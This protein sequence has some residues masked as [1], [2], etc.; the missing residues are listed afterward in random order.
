MNPPPDFG[1]PALG[2]SPSGLSVKSAYELQPAL[3]RTA[4][5][6]FIARATSGSAVSTQSVVQSRGFGTSEFSFK[7][8]DEAVFK[9][10]FSVS[11]EPGSS[12][13]ASGPEP[14]GSTRIAP[15]GMESNVPGGAGFS[16]LSG[17]APSSL[18]FSFSRPAAAPSISFP[19]ASHPHKDPLPGPTS[20]T[21]STLEFTFSHPAVPSNSST[22]Q[23][24]GLSQT[25]TIPSSP[26]SFSFSAKVLQPTAGSSVSL[27]GGGGFGQASAFGELKAKPEAALEAA[28]DKGGDSESTGEVVFGGQGKGT[29][30]KEEPAAQDEAQ[31]KISKVDDPQA[32]GEA[33]RHPSKRPL[34]RSRFPGGGLFR[35]AMTSLM[36]SSVKKEAKEEEEAQPEWEEVTGT[37]EAPQSTHTLMT[38][39]RSQAP[40]REI[41]EKAEETETPARRSRRG[42]S[43]DSLGGMSPSDAT[44]IQCKNVPPNLNRKDIIEKH[45]SRFGKL[46]RVFCRPNKNLAI[47]HFHDH[48]S[49]A[50]AKKRGKSLHRHEILIFWQRKK[51]SPGEKGERYAEVEQL[52]EVAADTR[53]G[54]FQS[55]PLRKPLARSPAVGSAGSLTKGSPVKKSSIAKTLQFDLE[56]QLESGSDSPGTAAS[57]PSSLQ[58]L[59]GQVCETAEE[60]YRLL[61]QRDKILRQ[62]R[63][64]RTDLDMSKVFVGTCP[65]MC[66]EKERYMRETRNQLSSYEVVPNTEKVDHAAAIKEYSRS[67]ADQEEP[68]PHELRPLPVLSMTMDYLVTQVMDQGQEN[69]RDWYDFVWNR[70]RG[71]R[72]DITQQHLCDPLTVSLIEKCTRFHIHCAHHL[73]QEPMMS[74]D[75]KIN[76]E[77]MTK[78]LQ[79]LKEMYQDLATREV[80]CSREAEFRQ[81]NVLLKLNDGDI[82]REVQQFRSE[83]RNST[84]VNFAVQAFAALNNNNFVRFFKLV[85]AASYLAGCILHRYFNQ[86]RRE[87]LRALN[88]A[89]TVGAQRSTSFPVDDLVRMLMFRNSA[90]AIDFVQ[91]YGLSVCEGMVELNRTAFQDPELPVPLKKS[92]DIMGKMT[93]LIG[94]VVNGGPLPSPPQHTPVYSFDSHNKYRGE[95][96]YVDPAFVHKGAPLGAAPHKQVLLPQV[97]GEQEPGE[98]PEPASASV[99]TQQLFPPMGLP[100]PAKPPSSPPKPEPVYSDQD[101]TAEIESV[102]DEVLETECSELA[103]AVNEYVSTA[104]GVCDSQVE[105]VMS[106]VLEQMLRDLSAAEIHMEKERIAEEKRKMEEARRKEEHELFLDQFGE[107]LCSEISQEVLTE[108]IKDTAELEIKQA[109]EEKAACLARSSEEV[110]HSLIEETLQDEISQLAQGV[111]EVELRRIYK[112]LKRWHDVVA[113]RRQLK[114][115]MRGFPAAPCF[116]DPRFKLKALV[117]SV[118]PSLCMER[119]AQGVV[120]LGN[121]GHMAVSCTRLLK[122][123]QEAI[124]QM[125][126]QHYYQRLLSESVW[127]PLDLP[128][129]VAESI[130]DHTNRIFWKS[131]LLLPSNQESD[132]SIANR[133][134]TDWLEAKFCGDKKSC[135]QSAA[136]EGKME[137]LSISNDLLSLA[138]GSQEVHTCVKVT[139]GPLSEEGQ[140]VMEKQKELLGTSA[141][142]L[143]LPSL[144]G[145]REEGGEDE[146]EVFLLSALLQLRQL[147]QASAGMPPLP[148]VVVVPE[149]GGPT[150][151]DQ[152]LEGG[153]MLPALVEDGLISEYVFIHIPETINDLQ[154]S[155][156]VSQAVKWLAARSPPPVS[157]ASQTLVEFV[158][159]GLCREFSARLYQDKQDREGAG[160]PCQEPAPIIR[161]YNSVLDFLSGLVSADSLSS[162]SWPVTEFCT[163]ATRNLLPHLDWNCPDHL[164]WIRRAVL[165]LQIPEWDLP[166]S[167]A[168]WPQLCAS[169]FQYTSQIPSSPHSQ[170]LLMSRLENLLGRVLSRCSPGAILGPGCNEDEECD[171][172]G[173]SFHQVPW[174]EILAICIDHRLKDW[175]PPESPV[176]EDAITED[177][178]ILVYFQREKLKDFEPPSCW[179]EAVNQTHR[180]KQQ[181]ADQCTPVPGQGL[182]PT[183]AV[184]RLRQNLFPS[185]VETQPGRAELDITYTPSPRELLP[186]CILASLQDEKTKNQKFEEQLQ[187]WLEK[188]PLDSFSMP[189][190]MPSS[191]ISVPEIMAPASK[192]TVS[193]ALTQEM[194]T[195][196]QGE[197]LESNWLRRSLSLDQRLK[198][199]K[200]L[201]AASQKEERACGL[202]LNSLLEIVE[203]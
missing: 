34:M 36:K 123:R 61:E 181:Q 182:T 169:I 164:A 170:P 160:L 116:V 21:N 172:G 79:S 98:L 108:C 26:S 95:G 149:P 143:L 35:S 74:F 105:A 72:K 197:T 5:C 188:D 43:T 175:R 71:I 111:L 144:P 1:Q 55:S 15:T 110:S 174:D 137:T 89:Y 133:I 57:L 65:D 189:A 40:T 166:P 80:Y 154:G 59:V 163:P 147:Q 112:F 4:I 93:V 184:T 103:R 3:F 127:T 167:S 132:A 201:M 83:V 171:K 141:L 49:A 28:A 134:L 119:L 60:K 76:N 69:Y 158:E 64:K 31:G 58:H 125:R 38:P 9:P 42:E 104:L 129:L 200:R 39:P 20:N 117:P 73:C 37:E 23:G 183:P 106:E 126:V 50:R 187:R 2:Q 56:P 99:T 146:E 25:A 48:A 150:V 18:G 77:N 54:G 156:Q 195:D 180:D 75:A 47:V 151:S 87:A 113:V 173:L 118:S 91:Q 176:S 162:L 122:M 13:P 142:L 155:E 185:L 202:H 85:R 128:T 11:P 84:E 102:L 51:Q 68:L 140:S 29:K 12:Q 165:S 19:S 190:F 44:A 32:G 97:A 17:D 199:L 101:I 96:L 130:P 63:P 139:R 203:D 152:K 92:V 124:H 196:S 24:G 138:V 7:P 62:G 52:E 198:E 177:G 136:A 153:L 30:R 14:S 186:E 107:S 109:L 86:V 82:L 22:S 67:S 46:R 41:I 192:T 6:I 194:E 179:T 94:E 114:R 121:A 33:T 27:F 45:F 178:E 88:V 66:P 193:T 100:Q 8:A 53:G 90:E 16:L 191:L 168:S 157:L 120:H 131:V 145:S 78:C 70:T 161:L 81:Y 135:D 115:Q 10:I 159:A 148:L